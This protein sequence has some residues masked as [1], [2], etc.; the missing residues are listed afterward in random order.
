MCARCTGEIA[1]QYLR[2]GD[3]K[4]DRALRGD[5]VIDQFPGARFTLAKG[6]NKLEN[7][8]VFQM[9]EHDL[10]VRVTHA[11]TRQAGNGFA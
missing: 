5:Q 7:I 10:P 2:S 9:D 3:A 11:R 6:R 8:I 4:P 1:Q